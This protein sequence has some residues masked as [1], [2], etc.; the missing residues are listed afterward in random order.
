MISQLLRFE[1]SASITLEQLSATTFDA[2]HLR[3]LFVNILF[4]LTPGQTVFIVLHALG[5]YED[6]KEAT[7]VLQLLSELGHLPPDPRLRVKVF[8][9]PAVPMA[10][11]EILPFE[12][13]M[14]LND[15]IDEEGYSTQHLVELFESSLLE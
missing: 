10:T 2:S 13:F 12:D 11:D 4:S 8:L 5:Y 6:Q 15:D 3:D 9:T 7:Y 1:N 14:D